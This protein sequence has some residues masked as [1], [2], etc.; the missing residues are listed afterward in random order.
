MNTK[1]S[2]EAGE[3]KEKRPKQQ[4]HALQFNVAQLLKKSGS[5]ARTYMIEEARVPELEAEFNLAAPLNG[6]IKFI[7]TDKEIFVTGLLQTQL[8]MAC[9]RCLED[10]QTS[11]EF[12]LEETFS[13]TVDVMTGLK[14]LLP[15]DTDQA[16]LISDQ[17]ILDLSEVARQAIHLHEPGHV[18][19]R[20]DCQGLC[21]QC[22]ANLNLERC[23]CNKEEIDSRWAGLL[24]L[25][26]DFA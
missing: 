15:D 12:D 25:K 19:C 7:K 16:T 21:D 9:T 18:L 20:E 10:V 24:A 1:Q 6:Q 14:L 26:D 23:D 2:L 11:L 17:H 8:V 5:S 4:G 22:G 3:K 13:P